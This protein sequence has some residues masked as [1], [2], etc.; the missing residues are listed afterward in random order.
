MVIS[1][2]AVILKKYT[3]LFFKYNFIIFRQRVV[4]IVALL[5]KCDFYMLNAF[6]IEL[7][8]NIITISAIFK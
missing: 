5:K 8:K 4:Y 7:I 1:E 3:L 2:S 6:I